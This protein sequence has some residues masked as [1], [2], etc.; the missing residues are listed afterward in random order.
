MK[1]LD[2]YISK[3]FPGER[4]SSLMDKRTNDKHLNLPCMNETGCNTFNVPQIQHTHQQKGK[5]SL[6]AKQT[7]VGNTVYQ[8]PHRKSA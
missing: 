6:Q 3:E 4:L 7:Q 5:N 8:S 2:T 1:H